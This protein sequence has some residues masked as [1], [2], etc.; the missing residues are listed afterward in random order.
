M[1]LM[2]KIKS[3]FNG[4]TFYAYRKTGVMVLTCYFA[5]VATTLAIAFD[6]I[7]GPEK[8]TITSANMRELFA[9][10]FMLM[11]LIAMTFGCMKHDFSIPMIIS[12]LVMAFVDMQIANWYFS[13][14]GIMSFGLALLLVLVANWLLALIAAVLQT[15][16][17]ARKK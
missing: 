12:G 10:P 16:W 17:E 3:L 14:L 2:S 7:S 15:L 13:D 6:F 1:I 11:M 5:V 8:A 4:D 9:V